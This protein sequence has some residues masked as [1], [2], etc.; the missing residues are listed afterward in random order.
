MTLLPIA[1]LLWIGI[2]AAQEAKKGVLPEVTI[3]A[4]QKGRLKSEKPEL[5]LPIDENKPLQ[6]FLET[7]TAALQTEPAAWKDRKP[8]LPKVLRSP[9]AIAP[10][11]GRIA[12]EPVAIFRPKEDLKVA[13]PDGREYE[14]AAW[15]YAVADAAGRRFRSW[16]SDGRSRKLPEEI[17]FDGRGDDGKMLRP[18]LAYTAVLTYM[19]PHGTHTV[20]G[21]TIKLEGTRHQEPEGAYIRLDPRSLWPVP[22]AQISEQT[23]EMTQEGA[24]L[25]QEAADWIKRMYAAYPFEVRVFLPKAEAASAAAQ[26]L[27]VRLARLL[28]RLPEDIPAVGFSGPASEA[29]VEIAVKNR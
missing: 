13:H 16:A 2:G 10:Y 26:A 27:R 22:L 28:R 21:R 18:G 25:F 17:L 7:S 11:S 5:V 14:N 8:H 15:N 9:L 6:P 24:E 20:V 4:E 3:K 19:D 12:K 29:R 23:P 1:A